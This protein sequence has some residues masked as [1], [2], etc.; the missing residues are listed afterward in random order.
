MLIRNSHKK[1]AIG[2]SDADH[3]RRLLIMAGVP[4]AIIT[5][6]DDIIGYDK[7]PWSETWKVT[8]WNFYWCL[9]DVIPYKS[10]D[11]ETGVK[12]YRV[13]WE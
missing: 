1:E 13:I 9:N 12:L 11:A 10:S 8:L 2:L 3:N 7:E 4:S 6:A 5:S